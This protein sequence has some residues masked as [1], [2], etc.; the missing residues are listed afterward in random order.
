MTGMFP[1]DEEEHNSHPNVTPLAAGN[2]TKEEEEQ[3]FEDLFR[4]S[5]N[6]FDKWFD[7]GGNQI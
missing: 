1:W 5:H 4:E 6:A 3:A 2:V 7:E